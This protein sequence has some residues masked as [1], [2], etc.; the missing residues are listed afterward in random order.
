[1]M[2]PLAEFCTDDKAI[3]FVGA[4]AFGLSIVAILI[5]ITF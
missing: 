2:L 4:A 1:M 5:L 3:C